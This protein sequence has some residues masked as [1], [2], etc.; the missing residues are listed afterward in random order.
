MRAVARPQTWHT[1]C[2]HHFKAYRPRVHH[3]YAPSA[4]NRCLLLQDPQTFENYINQLRE[5]L[6]SVRVTLGGY[7][8][9]LGG[10]F[11]MIGCAYP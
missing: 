4:P 1:T 8:F 6:S 2:R 11:N 9:V 10:T 7:V 3:P 5:S